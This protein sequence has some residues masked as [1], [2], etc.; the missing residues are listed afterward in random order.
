MSE[1]V[2]V[3][4]LLCYHDWAMHCQS[5]KGHTHNAEIGQEIDCKMYASQQS[6]TASALPNEPGAPSGDGTI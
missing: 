4:H 2:E 1:M 5:A 3:Q 6:R